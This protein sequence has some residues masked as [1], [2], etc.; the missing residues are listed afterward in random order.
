MARSTKEGE[1][2]WLTRHRK[3]EEGWLAR[4]RRARKEHYRKSRHPARLWRQT[5]VLTTRGLPSYLPNSLSFTY[6]YP[7]LSFYVGGLSLSIL[8]WGA[9][10]LDKDNNIF[11]LHSLDIYASFW[12][13]KSFSKSLRDRLMND[14]IPVF[15]IP[16]LPLVEQARNPLPSAGKQEIT[17]LSIS[18]SRVPDTMSEFLIQCFI[19]YVIT[20]S[21]FGA[22]AIVNSLIPLGSFHAHS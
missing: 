4:Q 6:N 13:N 12:P 7:L 22:Y 20:P 5:I 14:E 17:F 1:E 8:L 9:I 11:M 3:G 19:I 2:G 21:L 10:P 16:A 15:A 18:G